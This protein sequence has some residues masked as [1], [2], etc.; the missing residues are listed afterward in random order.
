VFVY[1]T[2]GAVIGAGL[3]QYVTHIRDRRAARAVVIE[4]VG[5]VEATYSTL[6][7]TFSG[8]TADTMAIEP[9]PQIE[10]YLAVL[11]A[12]A[13]IAGVPYSCLMMYVG[14]VRACYEVR[15]ME[16]VAD[17]LTLKVMKK[18]HEMIE[19]GD[20]SLGGPAALKEGLKSALALVKQLK[21]MADDVRIEKARYQCL[22]LLKMAIWHPWTARLALWRYSEIKELIKL[23][24]EGRQLFADLNRR[25]G[26][27]ADL[28]AYVVGQ[29]AQ[30]DRKEKPPENP[31]ADNAAD[32][33]EF[34][35]E[36]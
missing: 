31:S 19:S 9:L 4:H 29:L 23:A 34:R 3:T 28:T 33:P 21:S 18:V 36:N 6:K 24:D 20:E 26:D 12:S 22:S 17:G 2:I 13:L 32:G 16:V 11:E 35:L 10:E 30:Q 27:R 14:C 8:D 1:T 5:K 25:F 15:R 7:V